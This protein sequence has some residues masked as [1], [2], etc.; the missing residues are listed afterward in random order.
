MK[1]LNNELNKTRCLGT[2]N[3]Y[4]INN[5]VLYTHILI[6]QHP[7]THTHIGAQCNVR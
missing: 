7:H 4:K 2:L 3:N 6:P 1:G 5:I